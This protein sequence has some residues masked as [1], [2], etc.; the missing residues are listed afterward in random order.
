MMK[1]KKVRC[2]LTIR[3]FIVAA[4][5]LLGGFAQ[6]DQVVNGKQIIKFPQEELPSE[7][8]TPLVDTP[9]AVESPLYKFSHQSEFQFL[10]QSILEEAFTNGLLLG[11]RYNY[12]YSD[13]DFFGV[14]YDRSIPGLSSN[15]RTF[16]TSTRHLDFTR[17]PLLTSRLGGSWGRRFIYGKA[18]FAKDYV[19]AVSVS[20]RGDLG[21]GTY[22][23]IPCPYVTGSAEYEVFLTHTDGITLEIGL[24]YRQLPNILSQ[25]LSSDV[26]VP[27]QSSFTKIWTF[28]PELRI[29]YSKLF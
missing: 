9:D 7:V 11:A 13:T 18:S 2:N 15:A 21:L 27:D 14:L 28:S 26:A 17:G 25:D 23:S 1:V 22:G 5:L 20:F 10:G 29:G 4:L 19:R 16:E 6:A 3:S 8:V 24:S 12:Q